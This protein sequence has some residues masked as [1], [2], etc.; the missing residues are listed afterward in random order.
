MEWRETRDGAATYLHLDGK[1]VGAV[2]RYLQWGTQRPIWM[3]HIRPSYRF[4]RIMHS[5]LAG[6]KAQ[7]L[8]EIL[9]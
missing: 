9:H 4:N 8:Q 6:A 2:M 3:A 5:T 7:L 1:V